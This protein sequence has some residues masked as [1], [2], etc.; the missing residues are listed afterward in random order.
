[1]RR[2]AGPAG[3]MERGRER[4]TAVLRVEDIARVVHEAN[5]GLQAVIG[6]PVNPRWDEA[7]E[8]QRWSCIEGVRDAPQ[9]LTPEEHHEMWAATLRAEGWTRGPVK[10]GQAKTHPMLVPWEDLPPQ[11]QAKTRLFLAV[12]AALRD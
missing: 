10:D 12:V 5:S 7:P 6:E 3:A 11:Q 2:R 4:V 8:W 1:M 9:V